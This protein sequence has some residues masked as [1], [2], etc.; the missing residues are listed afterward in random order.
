M[1]QDENYAS[2]IKQSM[3]HGAVN[4]SNNGLEAG[5]AEGSV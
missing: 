4:K 1:T 2:A 5:G 3:I